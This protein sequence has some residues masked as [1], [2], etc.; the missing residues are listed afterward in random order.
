VQTGYVIVDAAADLGE[1]T[2]NLLDIAQRVL[3]VTTASVASLR[4][5]KRFLELA[6]KMDYPDEKIMLLISGYRKDD[7]SLEDIER[8]LSWAVSV[9][10]PSDSP[11]MALALNQGQPIV[12]RD[13]NHPIS[14]S[15]LK[16][17]RQLDASPVAASSQFGSDEATS[18]STP[19][20]SGGLFQMRLKPGTAAG[21]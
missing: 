15:I 21:S 18:S 17:A 11:V 6:R 8:H 16:L 5:T 1:S 9:A 7:I 13:R 20:R 3:L 10:V 2:L 12:A 14:K 19:S 4:A